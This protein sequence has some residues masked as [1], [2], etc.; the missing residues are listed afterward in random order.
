MQIESPDSRTVRNFSL[1]L[2]ADEAAS[3]TFGDML[4][5]YEE[6]SM[7]WHLDTDIKRPTY[8]MRTA[9][10]HDQL[11]ISSGRPEVVVLVPSRE[12]VIAGLVAHAVYNSTSGVPLVALNPLGTPEEYPDKWRMLVSFERTIAFV[13]KLGNSRG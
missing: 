12:L 10:R 9:W 4:P 3:A 1:D 2:L 13:D 7:Y 8:D 5:G 11:A 6:P